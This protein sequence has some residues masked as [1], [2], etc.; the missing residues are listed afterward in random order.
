M[1]ETYPQFISY[2]DGNTFIAYSPPDTSKATDGKNA[3]KGRKTW[4]AY[5]S[6]QVPSERVPSTGGRSIE[7]KTA[8]CLKQMKDWDPR[9]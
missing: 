1:C 3:T 5:C 9:M 6:I 4:S 7:N 8:F 2:L